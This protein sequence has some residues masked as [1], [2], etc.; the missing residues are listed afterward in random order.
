MIGI[1]LSDR[2]NQQT[3]DAAAHSQQRSKAPIKEIGHHDPHKLPAAHIAARSV[4]TDHPCAKLDATSGSVR[5]G[6]GP[7]A[8]HLELGIQLTVGRTAS[9]HYPATLCSVFVAGVPGVKAQ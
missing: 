3:D 8:I 2:Q 5:T 9:G 6:H 1:A 7:A 4:M